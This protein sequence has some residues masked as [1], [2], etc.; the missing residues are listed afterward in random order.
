MNAAQ[1]DRFNRF[2]DDHYQGILAE[3][4]ESDPSG[5]VPR[6]RSGFASAYRFWAKVEDDGDPVGWVHRVI[7]EDRRNPRH[8]AGRNQID[9]PGHPASVEASTER[10]RIVGLARRQRAVARVVLGTSA[11]VAIG[12][13]LFVAHR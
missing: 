3:V 1:L 11:L 8:A 13:E 4:A 12:A 10:R 9:E 2:F 7:A 6:T 5:S